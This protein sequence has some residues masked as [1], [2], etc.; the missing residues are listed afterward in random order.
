MRS[1]IFKKILSFIMAGCMLMTNAYFPFGF[2]TYALE[3]IAAET[4]FS[5]AENLNLIGTDSYNIKLPSGSTM[6]YNKI[7]LGDN[8]T[9]KGTGTLIANTISGGSLIM[10][11]GNVYANTISGTSSITLE[12]G[13]LTA[14]TI[15]VSSKITSKGNIYAKS[16]TAPNIVLSD[17][18]IEAEST[19]SGSVTMANGKF[20]A[21]TCNGSFT[22]NGGEA[23]IG[24]AGFEE[25]KPFKLTDGKLSV[26]NLSC[27]PLT[28]EG[29][30]IDS[31][32]LVSCKNAI[33]KSGKITADELVSD[34][35]TI[36]NGTIEIKNINS[37]VDD[38]IKI[39]GGKIKAQNINS[40]VV[41]NGGEVTTDYITARNSSKES[42][43]IVINNGTV[44]VT[45]DITAGDAVVTECDGGSISIISGVVT[46]GGN[47][48]AGS[49]TTTKSDVLSKGGSVTIEQN[50]GVTVYGN[51]TGG[52]GSYGT[53]GAAAKSTSGSWKYYY[54]DSNGGDG[55]DIILYGGKYF[56]KISGGEGGLS[57]QSY[58]VGC[59]KGGKGGSVYIYNGEING[60]IYGGQGG[61]GKD[62]SMTSSSNSYGTTYYYHFP[63]AGGN[64]G[65]VKING[66]VVNAPKGI[67]VNKTGS[68]GKTNGTSTTSASSGYIGKLSSDS[69]GTAFITSPAI[70][71]RSYFLSGVIY[72]NS[73]LYVYG[74]QKIN[75]NYS[76]DECDEL[77]VASG[78]EM[79]LSG[80][81]IN[82]DGELE[83]NGSII[84]DTDADLTGTG[85][86]IYNNEE[87]SIPELKE[88]LIVEMITTPDGIVYD[89]VDHK[90]SIA[91]ES[92]EA[93][94]IKFMGM[95]LSKY[96]VSLSYSRTADGEK[97]S[98][99]TA[100]NAGYYTVQLKNSSD[101]LIASKDFEITRKELSVSSVIATEGDSEITGINFSGLVDGETL[102]FG[103]D[104]TVN[105]AVIEGEA[106]TGVITLLDTPA[107]QNYSVKD[108]GTFSCDSIEYA[109]EH[110]MTWKYDEE[111]HWKE[112]SCG[113]Q[114]EKAAH[115]KGEGVVVKEATDNS[116]GEITY[117]CTECGYVMERKAIH[118]FSEEWKSDETGHWK[119]CSCGERDT[120]YPHGNDEG[121]TGIVTEEA[122][123]DKDGVRTFYCK[124]CGYAY[125]TEP[126]KFE[127]VHAAYGDWVS[128]E[129]YH[130]HICE[131][132]EEGITFDKAEH[133]SDS[134]TIVK[135]A[136]DT[137]EG[138]IRYCCTVCGAQI[139]EVTIPVISD[140]EGKCGDNLFWAYDNGTLTISG[141]GTMYDY[142]FESKAP[143]YKYNAQITKIIVQSGT[144]SIGDVAF[145]NLTA[146]TEISL[147]DSLESIGKNAFSNCKVLTEISVP[148]KVSTIG[149]AAFSSCIKLEK[150]KLPVN[151]NAISSSMFSK[152][153]AL[154]NLEIPEKVTSVETMSFYYC[155]GLTSITIP[156]N[157]TEIGTSAFCE[158]ENLTSVILGK[159]LQTIEAS[160]FAYC[161][162]MEDTD[163]PDTVTFIGNSAFYDCYAITTMTIPD[164][165]EAIY[166]CTFEN[167]KALTSISIPASVTLIE[168]DAFAGC[169]KITHIHIP[170]GKT[171]SD[172]SAKGGLPTD[173]NLF[174]VLDENENCPATNCPM[175]TN[176]SHEHDFSTEY[177]MDSGSHW[178]QCECG[179]K[180]DYGDHQPGTEA[181]EDTPQ[182][183][184][185]CGYEITPATGHLHKNHLT[186]IDS[187]S[188][189]CT[190]DGTKEHYRCDC[191][192]LF[193]DDKAATEVSFES[194][195]IAAHHNFGTEWSSDKDNHYHICTVCG[196]TSEPEAH[197]KDEGTVIKEAT[198]T[199]DGTI[200]Y[201]CTVCSASMTEETVSATIIDVEVA[202]SKV[203]VT[204]TVS[205]SSE[206]KTAD[207][208]FDKVT[209]AIVDY[210]KSKNIQ[211]VIDFVNYS[212]VGSDNIILTPAQMKAIEF[213]LEYDLSR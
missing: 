37:K 158:C 4:D 174:F 48:T 157:V 45:Y 50:A 211:F 129:T 85:T 181:T 139:R 176:N 145:Y 34:S 133:T 191:G 49:A 52:T 98:T 155:T 27:G 144:E 190:T 35:I 210:M 212:T 142:T 86:Y 83:N 61:N 36:S 89:G 90:E 207:Y 87:I 105:D 180:T 12:A 69:D 194:L 132:G 55:G 199:E 140:N 110:N 141:T 79:T 120:V 197:N 151:L 189:T 149:F 146:L 182:T 143:W 19:I 159:Q 28:M 112:C 117:S 198:P 161:Y 175:G 13:V 119:E 153:Y 1:K 108:N 150:V 118:K 51:I 165:V 124:D 18:V 47:I 136:T 17:G 60:D 93:Y 74:K 97:Q 10:E 25:T 3:N 115:I 186:K 103:T 185:V 9:I 57:G 104:Y 192:K 102:E 135:A 66:G 14:N 183:C 70:P 8:V 138:L 208:A 31:C 164:G 196:E 200:S 188:E 91:L 95:D 24:T 148:D 106:A 59:T 206:A 75:K 22:L 54:D 170:Y 56:G 171:A 147:P 29:G 38:P 88:K 122:T 7:Y 107:A 76:F 163:I 131:C 26:T 77:I 73:D 80:A 178:R 111:Q 116:D 42:R 67:Y 94:G 2:E 162:K 68:A 11:N 187:V 201:K 160:A 127:H 213:V 154:K 168:Q 23:V 173:E 72:S 167:C 46:V 84:I 169:G 5:E 62:G 166:G 15:T 113:E 126:V 114:T 204:Y 209:E 82:V 128:D 179:E 64:S 16:I 63:G 78:A 184:T 41:I 33:F 152:C 65:D 96:D 30:E 134:G 109:H 21:A 20:S 177:Y 6:I 92:K 137:E 53:D 101:E 130:W 203:I 193:A 121:Y 195:K 123:P 39:N 205:G 125:R 99:E 172:Y 71:S 43:N 81:V 202:S 40:G 58:K 32:T 44:S 156:D 100:R